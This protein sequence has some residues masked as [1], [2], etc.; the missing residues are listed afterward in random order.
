MMKSLKKLLG[1]RLG[2]YIRKDDSEEN[3]S[4]G[5]GRLQW[6]KFELAEYEGELEFYIDEN[7][8]TSNLYRLFND[9]NNEYIDAVLLWSLEDIDLAQINMLE[10]QCI[11]KDVQVVSFC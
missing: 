2:V 9:I 6:L 4:T 8:S 10:N 11:K 5:Y 7:N 3:L 1:K